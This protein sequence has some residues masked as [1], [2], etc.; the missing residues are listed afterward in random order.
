MPPAPTDARSDRRR[1]INRR[2]LTGAG[3][4]SAFV[5][6]IV[7]GGAGSGGST[8][9]T[10]ASTTT[11][12]AIT[13]ATETTTTTATVTAEPPA[14]AGPTATITDGIWVVGTDIQPGTY[15][16]TAAVTQSCYWA[17]Y[18][19]GTNTSKII[20]N[21]TVSGGFPQVTLTTGQDFRS[22]DC[23]TWAPKS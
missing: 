5:L 15:R 3:F 7:V 8:T 12:T 13:T 21:D 16:V 23:G 19:S 4:V 20:E 10:P 2:I 18:Q 1:T 6:G 14:P 22:D 11:V 9:A 17:I